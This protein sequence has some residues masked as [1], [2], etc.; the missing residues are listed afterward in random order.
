MSDTLAKY[1]FL[2]FVRL[3]LG[4]QI[5]EQD[6]LGASPHGNVLER[7]EVQVSINVKATAGATEK[8][9][10]VSRIVKIEGPGDVLGIQA[11]QIIRVHPARGVD[12]FEI[13]NLVYIEFYEE[14]FPW[15]FSPASPS[16]NNLRPWLAVLVLKTD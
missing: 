9:E 12:N 15:R 14:D 5:T 6:T 3:G 4:N 8:N 1:S 2:P 10:P 7:P 13:N 11:N 16:G